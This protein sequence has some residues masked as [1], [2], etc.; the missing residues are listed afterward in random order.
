MELSL[1]CTAEWMTLWRWTTIWIFSGG[2]PNSHL[3]PHVPVGVAEGVLLLFARQL[4][5]LHPKE[6]PA[7]GG[8]QDLFESFGAVGVLQ[9]LEDGRVFAVHRQQMDPL[10]GHR[11]GHQMAAG[12]QTLLVGQGQVV[13]ALDGRQAGPQARDAHHAVQNHVRPIQPGQGHQAL[14]APEQPGSIRPARQSGVHCFGGRRVSDADVFRVE[15][16]DLLQERFHPAVGRKA[17]HL[18]LLG[19]DHVQALGADGTGGAQ[20]G[21]FLCHSPSPSCFFLSGRTPQ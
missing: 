6:R 8:Q 21:D 16:L 12:D 14:G 1:N 3:G 2:R 11:L 17:E 7:R 10:P 15:F 18:I 20:Q 19:P 4:G 9:T 5:G 13:A